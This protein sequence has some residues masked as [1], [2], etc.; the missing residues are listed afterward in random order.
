MTTTDRYV[1]FWNAPT[2]EAMRALGAEVFT[3]DLMYHAPVGV[4][5]GA[6]ALVGFATEFRQHMGAAVFTA[7][8]EPEEH[9]DRIRLRWEIVLPDGTSFAE[10][11][12]VISVEEDGRVR[13]VV[14][15]LDRAPAGFD[16]DAVH[17][18]DAA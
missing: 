15:F 4:L 2:P 6:E 11:T 5:T 14:S 8:S 7:R 18:H 3:G 16:P 10:G 17:D 1:A 13:D 9:H 12:D